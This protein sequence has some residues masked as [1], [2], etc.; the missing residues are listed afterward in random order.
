MPS[1]EINPNAKKGSERD[2]K[3]QNRADA[4]G[5]EGRTAAKM[6]QK[7]GKGPSLPGRTQDMKKVS[8]EEVVPGIKLVDVIL[9]EEK[10]G[11]GMYY[12]YTDKKCKKMPEGLKMTARFGGGGHE[13]QEVG[14]DKPVEGGEGGNGG[15]G[16]GP[17]ESVSIEDA[18]GNKFMEVVDLIKPEDITEKC[19]KGYKKKGMKTMFGKRYPNCVKANEENETV[20]EGNQ[21]QAGDN[22]RKMA[23]M[24]AERQ[25]AVAKLMQ[26]KEMQ[27]R[28][29][30]AIDKKIKKEKEEQAKRMRGEEVEVDEKYQGMYQ[31][32]APTHNRL[33]SSDE[34]ARMSPGRRAMA[35]SDELEKSQ[36]GS[37]R[38]KAQK[39]A[40]MQMARNFKSARDTKE[41]VNVDEAVRLQ[42]EY[43][44]LL[45]VVV[46]WR[47]RSLMIKM[48]FPQASMPKREDVQREIEKV[49]PGGKVTHFH[50]TDLPSEYSPHNAPIVRVQKEEAEC[51]G[52]PKGK[53][54][55]VHGQKC[56]PNLSEEEVDEAAGEKDACYHK[57]KS[58]Y[59]VWPSAYASG[60]LVKCRKKGAK[61][62]GNKTK[63]EEF[64]YELNEGWVANTA[65][66]A[67]VEEGLNE[68]GVAILIEE[69]GLESFVEFVYD[70]GEDTMLSEARAG[71]VRVEPVTKGG[72]AVGSLK[73]GPK[74]AAIK[75]LRKEKQARRDAES[76]SS[77]PSGM[78]AALKSQSDR[79]K[80]VKSAK[81]QQPKK[82]GLLDKVA[83]TVLDGMDR[84]NKAMK[85][86]KGDIETTKKVAK[87]AGK[88]AK[89]FGSG[90]VSGVKTA[91]K[92][93]KAGYKMATEEEDRLGKSDL[94]EATPRPK[95][96]QRGKISKAEAQKRQARADRRAAAQER[97]DDKAKAGIDAL[98]GSDADRKAA[99]A[100]RANPEG[101]RQKALKRTIADRMA[102]GA[103]DNK[104]GEKLN[105]KKADMGEVIDDFY[106]SDAPQFKGKSKEKRRQMAIAAKLQANE[107]RFASHGGKDTD[108]GS[109]YAK[110]SKG[111]NKK[112]VYTLKGKDGKPLFDKN[113]AIDLKKK[114]SERKLN[115]NPGEKPE[116]AKEYRKNS[117]PL[118]KHREKF[119]D[120]AKEDWQSVNRKDKTD[121][122]SQKA[123][124]AYRKENP[125]SKLKTAV[126]KK[127]S[128]LKKGSKDAKRRSSFCSRM[129]GMKKRLTSAKTARDPDSRI[130]KALRRW[131]CN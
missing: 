86:A 30:A 61:N 99:A 45:A 79:A 72:K 80:A 39:K 95:A 64:E 111:G 98:I 56:C 3:L 26:S 9:G 70:L 47:G 110:P 131:N 51:A 31:S 104:L 48:F 21:P 50:R 4:G 76:G 107:N 34:K 53:D 22:E 24:G 32:P 128:E 2:K 74:A 75:R 42:A 18:F 97:R 106:D 96:T 73:G 67:F 62:W 16:G 38:A 90:F 108:A 118:R 119:G 71:G 93:A 1:F 126:T 88:A 100:A 49:Y 101:Q 60:A 8:E 63:K 14:I 12:C 6:L 23:K 83:K 57:V 11:K 54:C 124:N 116:S 117:E 66:K 114:S 113:E 82:R 40:S 92:V 5:V 33:K 35:K 109:A 84:H 20:D 68:E 69:M 87:K 19:W 28:F 17:S 127:P 125:G 65:A 37:K 10:C 91:G 29:D 36:P 122:L 44:N 94:D 81:S 112:G 89:S 59:S 58:R 15:N 7:K 46:M 78:K 41:E 43:G 52:T 103:K 120:L 115:T 27:K 85:K 123:V 105:L 102:K 13:P 55:P 130:N 129:K 77:K 121:G 25:N